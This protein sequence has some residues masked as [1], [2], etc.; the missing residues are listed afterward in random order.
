MKTKLLTSL[1]LFSILF[2]FVYPEDAEK[3]FS[4]SER[5]KFGVKNMQNAEVYGQPYKSDI[6]SKI[7]RKM[8]K[9]SINRYPGRCPCPYN[10]ASNGSSC[11]GRSAY[12][13]RGGY[14]VLCYPHDIN[15]EMLNK[16]KEN[17]KDCDDL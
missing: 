9:E 12:S 16:Y 5:I 1:L 2:Y 13:R 8:I 14:S 15:S 6:D 4:Y 3:K 10:S 11:G 17:C 7:R